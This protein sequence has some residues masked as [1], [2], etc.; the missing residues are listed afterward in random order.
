MKKKQ[1]RSLKS[2]LKRYN[3]RKA[4]FDAKKA[5]LRKRWRQEPS[6]TDVMWAILNDH[7]VEIAKR[8]TL[9]AQDLHWL[10]M[11]CRLKALLLHDEG[12]DPHE[13]L[14]EAAKWE[15]MRM[16][17]NPFITG[18]R[19]LAVKNSCPSCQQLNGKTFAIDEALKKMPIPNKNCTHE[20]NGKRGWCRCMYL[21]VTMDSDKIVQRIRASLRGE[22]DFLD[23]YQGFLGI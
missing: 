2:R 20:Y 14:Q 5:E 21:A 15:L 22:D 4:E 17:Q 19:I 8:G 11:N 6:D 1:P 13:L 18:V 7:T 3:I 16:Q 23:K 9:G 10:K 12:R